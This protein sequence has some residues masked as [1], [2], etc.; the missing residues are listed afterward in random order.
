MSGQL[1]HIKTCIYLYFQHFRRAEHNHVRYYL[2]YIRGR[3]G[4]EG[5]DEDTHL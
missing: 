2:I 4:E 5:E 1:S 3:S